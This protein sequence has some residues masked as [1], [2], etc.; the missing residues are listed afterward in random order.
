MRFFT[1]AIADVQ[2]LWSI[3]R[4][5]RKHGTAFSCPAELWGIGVRG[6]LGAGFG[7]GRLTGWIERWVR[8]C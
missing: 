6:T 8:R 5:D 3:R 7:C 2:R 1:L 4:A